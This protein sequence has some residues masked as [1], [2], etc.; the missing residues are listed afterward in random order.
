VEKTGEK[1]LQGD[2]RKRWDKARKSVHSAL[3]NRE[4]TAFRRILNGKYNPTGKTVQLEPTD[5]LGDKSFAVFLTGVV[6]IPLGEISPEV[7]AWLDEES[8]LNWIDSV[9]GRNANNKGKTECKSWLVEQ[10]KAGPPT[11]NKKG[12]LKEAQKR[13]DVSE[14]SFSVARKAAIEETGNTT[15]SKPGR[16]AY[17][18]VPGPPRGCQTRV[19]S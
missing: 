9:T 3:M 14:R 15:W 1:A 13:F 10:M 12:Y 19:K 6:K 16:M 11:Q 18:V 4:L 7:T 17:P 5:W 8:A 2:D